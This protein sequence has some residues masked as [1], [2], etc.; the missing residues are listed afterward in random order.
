[1]P[2]QAV[3]MSQTWVE[4][5]YVSLLDDTLMHQ[6]LID[7]SRFTDF[8]DLP[9]NRSKAVIVDEVQKLP[10]ILNVAHMQIQ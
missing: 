1:M 7:F 5:V 3:A 8:I 4:G 6:L 9:Q 10:K 2:I